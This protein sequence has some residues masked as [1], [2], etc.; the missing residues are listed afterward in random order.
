MRWRRSTSISSGSYPVPDAD[1][2]LVAFHIPEIPAAPEIPDQ[3]SP[4]KLDAELQA[5]K[6]KLLSRVR[7]L[8]SSDIKNVASLTADIQRL[9]L[10]VILLRELSRDQEDPNAYREL[11]LLSKIAVGR[12]EDEEERVAEE[13]LTA[14]EGRLKSQNVNPEGAMRIARLLSS[15]MTPSD[16]DDDDDDDDDGDD[17]ST[18][19]E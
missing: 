7:E 8:Q 19:S 13:D 1:A 10:A 9:R 14:I 6:L 2:P 17:K 11:G 16:S 12:D 18:D 15:V 5:T 3:D 4:L